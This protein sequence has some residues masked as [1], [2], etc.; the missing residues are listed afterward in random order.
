M[1]GNSTM[2]K[3]IVALHFLPYASAEARLAL[4]GVAFFT[5]SVSNGRWQAKQ[6]TFSRSMAEEIYRQASKSPRIGE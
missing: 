6:K 3:L 1:Q 5:F 4:N 2:F